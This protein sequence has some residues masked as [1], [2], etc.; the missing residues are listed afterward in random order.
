M[1]GKPYQCDLSFALFG[2]FKVHVNEAHAFMKG[3][4]STGCFKVFSTAEQLDQHFVLEHRNECEIC[5][6]SFAH[7]GYLQVCFLRSK[8]EVHCIIQC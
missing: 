2:E 4:L 1:G 6:K 8:C 3:H 7:L 5:G